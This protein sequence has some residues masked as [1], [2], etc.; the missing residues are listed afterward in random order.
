MWAE[1]MRKLFAEPVVIGMIG[2]IGVLMICACQ[3]FS[4]TRPPQRST[5]ARPAAP[6][7][8]YLKS[9]EETQYV[10]KVVLKNGLTV[11]VN[12]H[13][14]E[15]VVEIFARVRGGF[16]VE[17]DDAVGIS[18]LLGQS[19]F[20]KTSTRASGV[21]RQEIQSLG[22]MLHSEAAYDH[23]SCGITV[24]SGQWKRALEIQADVYW[25]A[26][27]DEADLRRA[28][29]ELLNEEIEAFDD[30]ESLGRR[31]LLD[32]AFPQRSIAGRIPSGNNSL[33]NVTIGQLTNYYKSIF[34]PART[35]IVIAGDVT[36]SEVL[37]EAVRLYGKTA[38]AAA[39]PAAVPADPPQ[40]EL[41]YREIRS[42]VETPRVYWG[43][44]TPPPGSEDF[45]SVA[46]LCAILGSGRGSVIEAHLKDQKEI[47]LDST[48][49]LMAYRDLSYFVLQLAVAPADI[50]RSEIAL[51]TEIEILQLEGPDE[52]DMERARAQLEMGSWLRRETVTGRASVLAHYESMGDWKNIDSYV[53]R[54]GRI[55]REDV[56]RVAEKYLRLDNCALLEQIPATSEARNLSADA[57]SRTFA[58]VL[59]PAVEQELQ[60]R[61]SKIVAAVKF[62]SPGS[63]FKFS[64]V[65]YPLQT[66]SILRGP[67]LFIRENHT[68]PLIQMG[69][70]FAGG[71]SGE[72]PQNSGITE[73][74]LRSLMRAPKGMSQSQF[75][76][77]L[78]IYGG[79]IKSVVAEDYFG[80]YLSILSRNI[81][82]G[83][84]LIGNLVKS[85]VFDPEAMEK[86][87]QLQRFE[88]ERRAYS[89]DHFDQ[90]LDQA[91]FS[92][93]AYGRDRS[94]SDA[95][96]AGLTLEAVQD[97]Y[98]SWV[99]NR[100]PVIILVGDTLGTSLAGYFVKNFSG[101]RFQD[102]KAAE[103]FPKALDKE[104]V[105]EKNWRRSNSLISIGFQA[106]PAG[107]DDQYA[108]DVFAS[109][110]S[111]ISGKLSQEFGKSQ[112]A[113][114]RASLDYLPLVQRGRI[115]LRAVVSS[116]GEGAALNALKQEITEISRGPD[117]YREYRAAINAAVGRRTINGQI[118]SWQIQQAMM[119][120]LAGRG[121]AGIAEYSG[122]LQDVS[123]EELEEFAGRALKLEKAVIVRLSAAP[124]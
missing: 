42:P 49:E 34:N 57:V 68:A 31:E 122:R 100:K 4:Q 46:V 104:I 93:H 63:A 56:Q 60:E 70:F 88:I 33:P 50:D 95:S 115:L 84:E 17:P 44:R 76:R 30:P 12:E 2:M 62:P 47:I 5:P 45:A 7:M 26:L 55:K 74:M 24:P 120:V 13:R 107:D 87:K 117:T 37:T 6:F 103:N 64:E 116:G 109:Y 111:G 43:F 40:T 77:Q 16:A 91:L 114:S 23:I 83:L 119:S 52:G 97:W 108:A 72:T 9:F 35:L 124:Q 3:G 71:K 1:K 54:I 28:Q 61:K 21:I 22:G 19:L 118:Y 102:S 10:T 75:H 69:F 20:H 123:Q 41:R 15:P 51:L 110:V 106:P 59:N 73:L 92:G 96:L 89:M 82:A 18:R 79:T 48:A 105:L 112:G 121:V 11:L 14:A 99:R 27:F 85:P 98:L 66:A 39:G 113:V 65:R 38:A 78:E 86:D 58:A 25:N 94:G 29:V 32:L 53:A 67:D 90:I 80:I 36:A 8:Q 81:D 101:S